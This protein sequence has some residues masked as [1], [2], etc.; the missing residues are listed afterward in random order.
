MSANEIVTEASTSAD[1]KRL[2]VLGTTGSIGVSTHDVVLHERDRFDVVTL[3]GNTNIELLAEQAIAV[4]AEIA[5]TADASRYQDL[6]ALLSGH[7][8]EV[9]AGA[10]AVLEAARRPADLTLAAI[11]GAAGLEPTLAAAEQGRTVALANKECLVCAGD[12]FKQAL[13]ESGATLLPVDIR[14]PSQKYR[15]TGDCANGRFQL[16]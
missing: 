8:I 13:E 6:K 9:A 3:V 1:V 4:D 14:M 16:P 11:V 15:R 2:T 5:V 12:V 7:D 10:D